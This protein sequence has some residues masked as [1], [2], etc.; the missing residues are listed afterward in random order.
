MRRA[1]GLLAATL[2]A[3]AGAAAQEADA[4]AEPLISAPLMPEDVAASAARHYPEVV[5][6][7]AGRDAAAGALLSARG[8]FDTVF[9]VETYSRVT[10]FYDGQFV[11]TKVE[12]AFGPGGAKA[13]GA[14]RLSDGDFPTYEDELFTNQSGELK[15]GVLF[16]LLRDRLIDSRR[17]GITDARLAARQ[18][19]LELLLTR[20][21]VQRRALLAYYAWVEA[22]Q[23]LG[24][25]R[26]LLDLAETRQAALTREVERGAR[27]RIVLTENA[28]NLTRRR[29]F[30]EQAERDLLLAGNALSLYLR[31]PDG[32]PRVPGAERLPDAV[33]APPPLAEADLPAVL[34]ARPDLGIL[35]TAL[36]RARGRLDLAENALRPRLDLGVEAGQD[37]GPID[38]D[39]GFSRDQGEV[40]L[41]LTFELPLANRA[42]RGQR[43]GARAALRRAEAEARL[44]RDR[45]EAEIRDVVV[46]VE[47]AE[48][49][50]VLATQEVEQAE[51]MRAAEARRFRSGAS[52]FF[53]VNLREQA[54]ADARIRLALA[55]LNL[56]AA[57]TTY[58]AAVLD[59]GRLGLTGA[60]PGLL[61]GP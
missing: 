16:S 50:V 60:T 53:L 43:A 9:S 24:V 56:Q 44:A 54:L 36:A 7:L 11:E 28:Q 57:R 2:C 51:A 5:A 48:R 46:S 20:I 61:T 31:G 40:I 41:G 34:A 32:A 37:L 29:V 6:A 47:A 55:Q 33:P 14:Y 39:A 26:D 52:D 35:R 8:A 58:D 22:G 4:P 15:V 19:D 3:L 59:E 25:Y 13:F 42:A 30:V 21:G 17:F 18:A 23:E 27:A 12:R 49:L 38:Q 1:L 45:I 10:G